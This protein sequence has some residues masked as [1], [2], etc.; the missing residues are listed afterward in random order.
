MSYTSKIVLL[1]GLAL[2]FF[3]FGCRSSQPGMAAHSHHAAGSFMPADQAN[4]PLL[5][6]PKMSPGATLPVTKDDLCV[7]GY[8]KKVR[9]VPADVK[10]QVY[11][12]YGITSH[13][14]GEYEVDHLISLELSGSNS[15]KNLWPQSYETQPWNAHVK[16]ALENKL[17]EE[18]CS[19]QIDLP[20]AQHDIAT[21]WIA[22]YK[23]YFHTTIPLTKGRGRSSRRMPHPLTDD[24]PIGEPTSMG[25]SA[26]G[27]S[28]AASGSAA[29]QVWVNLKSGKYFG[30][31]SRYYGNTKSGQYMSE[32]EAQ[33]QGY[34]A[35][36]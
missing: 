5:P 1:T 30:P 24:D 36:R 25:K 29:G 22:A 14:P 12:E 3:C 13:K 17:H 26:A 18:V 23:K 34:I 8:T 16:D 6:D 9:N 7:P 10:K 32:A 2:T 4:S 21:D 11:A 15:I 33:R 35:A 19:G 27:S 31:G 20:T 28:S